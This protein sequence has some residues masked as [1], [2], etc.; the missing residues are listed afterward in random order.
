M[1]A[2]EIINVVKAINDSATN[3]DCESINVFLNEATNIRI[4]DECTFF[5]DMDHA[6][7][8]LIK[9]IL[10]SLKHT[11]SCKYN[12][13]SSIMPDIQKHCNKYNQD[14]KIIYDNHLAK[15]RSFWKTRNVIIQQTLR[16]NVVHQNNLFDTTLQ[17]PVTSQNYPNI[18]VS[19]GQDIQNISFTVNNIQPSSTTSI[20]TSNTQ[21]TNNI[22]E[23]DQINQLL[24]IIGATVNTVTNTNDIIKAENSTSCAQNGDINTVKNGLINQNS[25]DNIFRVSHN[26]FNGI[27]INNI[28]NNSNNS[29]KNIDF[30]PLPFNTQISQNTH[31]QNYISNNIGNASLSTQQPF[32]ILPSFPIYMNSNFNNTKNFNSIRNKHSISRNGK[33]NTPTAPPKPPPPTTNFDDS[34]HGYECISCSKIFQTRQQLKSHQKTHTKNKESKK[35]KQKRKRVF[36]KMINEI[37]EINTS[38]IVNKSNKRSRKL[39]QCE[40]CNKQYS[41][42]PSYSD[43]YNH[44]LITNEYNTCIF[45]L[46]QFKDKKEL[47]QHVDVFGAGMSMEGYFKCCQCTMKFATKTNMQLHVNCVHK[48]VT[49][50]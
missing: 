15:I 47:K 11:P 12:N 10:C 20:Q 2:T 25:I 46:N 49:T 24:S 41:N 31:K 30:H 5:N 9:G 21:M 36:T 34:T 38:H 27:N 43:H 18:N 19:N 16:Q 33:S 3:N 37:D 50:I 44:H 23:S 29:M 42:L 17:I 14:K 6:V 4:L 45:C 28:N 1:S 48:N 40:Y 22:D 7:Q 35:S 39:F 13:L 8:R 32:N 26:I